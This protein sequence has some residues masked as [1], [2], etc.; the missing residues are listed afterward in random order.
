MIQAILHPQNIK[1]LMPHRI[2]IPPKKTKK[3][4]FFGP[5]KVFDRSKSF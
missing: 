3:K 4:Y 1:K 2:I 5:Q